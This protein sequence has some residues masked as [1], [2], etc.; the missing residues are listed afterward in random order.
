MDTKNTL[1]NS[2]K[3]VICILICQSVGIISGLL[4][5]AHNNLWYDSIIKPT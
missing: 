1:S 5:N 3:F 4:S 2:W